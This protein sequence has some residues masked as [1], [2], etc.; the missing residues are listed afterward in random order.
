M[1]I[2]IDFEVVKGDLVVV[3]SSNGADYN[4]FINH[5][6]KYE[7]EFNADMP[8]GG[9]GL[10][11]IKDFAKSWDYRYENNHSIITLSVPLKK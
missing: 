8:A 11:L 7:K 6:E 2:D 10:S 3:V 9:F 4:P 5:K 1:K